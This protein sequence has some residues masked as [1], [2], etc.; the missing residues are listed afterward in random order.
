MTIG[1]GI[2]I[3]S[4]ESKGQFKHALNMFAKLNDCFLFFHLPEKIDADVSS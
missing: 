3:S 2:Q 4:N 1:N